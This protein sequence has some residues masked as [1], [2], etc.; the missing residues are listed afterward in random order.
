MKMNMKSCVI[1][2]VIMAMIMVDTSMAACSGGCPNRLCCT[3]FSTCV[4]CG[5]FGTIAEDGG[6]AFVDGAKPP[7]KV[8]AASVD[9]VEARP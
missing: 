7:R 2:M 8:R 1:V 4:K 3:E 5:T 9:S 6:A